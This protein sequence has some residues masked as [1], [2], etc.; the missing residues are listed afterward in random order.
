MLDFLAG[1]S[2]AIVAVFQ[3]IINS[4]TSII[5]LVSLAFEFITYITLVLGHIPAPLLAFAGLGISLS[6]ILL[7][8][9][10]N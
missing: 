5:S 8:V 1:I 9:G 7:I 2:A 3:L 10:R 4:I 6:V